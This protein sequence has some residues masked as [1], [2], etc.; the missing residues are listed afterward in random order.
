MHHWRV[1]SGYF[2]ARAAVGRQHRP[3][4]CLS[5]PQATELVNVDGSFRARAARPARRVGRAG[6]LLTAARPPLAVATF[7]PPALLHNGYRGVDFYEV[8]RGAYALLHGGTISDDDQRTGWAP[9]R[10]S[11]PTGFRRSSRWRLARHFSCFRPRGPS[12]SGCSRRWP[13]LPRSPSTRRADSLVRR[14]SASRWSCSAAALL[15]STTFRSCSTNRSSPSRSRCFCSG[16]A[17]NR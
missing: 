2:T 1:I 8:P 7:F 4:R 10:P 3:R 6:H 12:E 15:P 9:G 5:R 11:N 16:S 14:T 13:V 17:A